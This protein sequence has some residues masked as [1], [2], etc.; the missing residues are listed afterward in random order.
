MKGCAEQQSKSKASMKRSP[1]AGRRLCIYPAGRWECLERATL[2]SPQ[3]TAMYDP[4]RYMERIDL[5]RT[6]QLIISGPEFLRVDHPILDIIL[7]TL[8]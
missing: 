5:P 2:R 4:V 3:V 1:R 6:L 7:G 8:A